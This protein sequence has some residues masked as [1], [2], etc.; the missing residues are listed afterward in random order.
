MTELFAFGSGFDKHNANGEGTTIELPHK[1]SQTN[2]YHRQ[3]GF[4]RMNKGVNVALA[5]NGNWSG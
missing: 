3:M 4:R 2:S 1:Y 5:L